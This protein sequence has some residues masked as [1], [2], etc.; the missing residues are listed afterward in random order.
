MSRSVHQSVYRFLIA[1]VLVASPLASA[2]AQADGAITT[3]EP[4]TLQ[5]C[6]YAGFAPF[7]SKDDQ[8]NWVGWDVDFLDGFAAA[9]GFPAANGLHFKPV[10]QALFNDI[11]LR[12][13][14]NECD[15]AATG[16]SDLAARHA[17]G[18]DWSN[19]Y[20]RVSRSYLVR[21]ADKD[22]LKGVCDLRGKTVIVTGGS[23]ADHDLRNRVKHAGIADQ[24]TI[25]ATDDEGKAAK[26]IHDGC[27]FAYGGGL[28][29]V[30]DQAR[31]LGGLEVVWT[32]CNT[33]ENGTQITP[34]DEPFSFVVRAASSGVLAALDQ[35]IAQPTVPYE[36]QPAPDL[37]CATAPP[38]ETSCP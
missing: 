32:H 22:K 19:H 30:Q 11:W 12:P 21:T 33:V 23:T 27:L 15:I 38:P 31:R 13:G 18:N 34:V 7:A 28:G 20:Y 35:Y 37:H 4:G 29:S 8:G 1:T 2:P 17:A 10:E 3:L 26:V 24:V 16:I 6:L 36:G 25:L 5:V 14:Q 9:N